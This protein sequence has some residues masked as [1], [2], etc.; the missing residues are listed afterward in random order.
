MRKLTTFLFVVAFMINSSYSQWILHN[1]PVPKG[2]LQSA[3]MGDLL[4][5]IG[6]CDENLNMVSTVDVYNAATVT[7]LPGT[8]ISS[9]RCFTASVGGDSAVYVAGGLANWSDVYGSKI[10]DIYKNGTWSSQALPDSSCFGQALHVGHKI[11]FAGHLKRFNAV[12]SILVPSDLVFVYDEL[13][14][15]MSV[16][17]LSQARTFLAAATNGTI[18]IFAGGS[19]GFNQ[20]SDVVDIYNSTTDTWSTATLSQAR[21][22]F[23]GIYAQGKFYFA[24][25]AGPGANLSYNTID[26]YDGTNWTTAQLSEARAG[27]AACTAGN[28]VFFAGGGDINSEELM[29]TTSSSMVD[30]YDISQNIWSTNNMNYTK[31]T[32]T[33]ISA[34]DKVY[35]AGGMEG[36]TVLDAFEI[37]DVDA[38]IG[39][40]GNPGAVKLFPNP[41]SGEVHLQLPPE[42]TGSQFCIHDLTGRLVQE[43]NILSPNTSIDITR[44][45]NGMYFLNIPGSHMP[46]VKLVRQ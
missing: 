6:G 30:V 5:F 14:Q 18:G 20:V 39:E 43:G 31:V 42:Y 40:S 13:T 2:Q 38:G 35:V 23:S 4:Y 41:S 16:D 26:I 24:G 36:M 22:N 7:W 25:G 17:T 45:V 1:M 29:Y 21:T 19:P 37:C 44:L 3:K 28:M 33:A 9:P 46:S 32:H 34:A 11:L 10:L 12:S 8:N 27:V 15:S